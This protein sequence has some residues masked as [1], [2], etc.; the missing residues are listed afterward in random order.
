MMK[1]KYNELVLELGNHFTPFKSELD[2]N[3]DNIVDKLEF[4]FKDLFQDNPEEHQNNDNLDEQN[5]VDKQN[6]MLYSFLFN[7]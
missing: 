3:L 4:I 5:R 6:T 1:Q 2:I 7:H